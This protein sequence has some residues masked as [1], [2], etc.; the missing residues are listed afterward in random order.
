V[1]LSNRYKGVFGPC[2]A[3]G[4]FPCFTSLL[5]LP[6]RAFVPVSLSS[7]V[8]F[9]SRGAVSVSGVLVFCPRASPRPCVAVAPSRSV[10]VGCRVAVSVFG[11]VWPLA[12]RTSV[13]FAHSYKCFEQ[14]FERGFW[15]FLCQNFQP[16]LTEFGPNPKSFSN[17]ILTESRS[18]CL[19]LPNRIR[20]DLKSIRILFF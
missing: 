2:L 16:N 12:F 19:W 3:F 4:R 5:C 7:R 11:S 1:S 6:C 8:A 17:R 9:L 18:L 14:V 10:G 20:T 13:R 15:V